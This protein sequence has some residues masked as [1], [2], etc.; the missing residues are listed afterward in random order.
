M[1]DDVGMEEEEEEQ[2]ENERRKRKK[3]R[4]RR[5]KGWSG[6]RWKRRRRR[7]TRSG[8]KPDYNSAALSVLRV[9]NDTLHFASCNCTQG[10]TTCR[11]LSYVCN[12]MDCD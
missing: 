3:R 9:H 7:G 1:V 8:M 12:P 5:K 6:R 4:R 10:L 11:A 2:E